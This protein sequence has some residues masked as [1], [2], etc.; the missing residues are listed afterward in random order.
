MITPF[1]RLYFNLKATK[2]VLRCKYQH[3]PVINF[4]GGKYFI[5]GNA[6]LLLDSVSLILNFLF[7]YNKSDMF[8][9]Y[10]NATIVAILHLANLPTT[11][12]KYLSQYSNEYRL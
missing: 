2:Y 6:Q 8:D 7:A 3:F 11:K 12:H 5:Y 9:T 4:P 1:L 10:F